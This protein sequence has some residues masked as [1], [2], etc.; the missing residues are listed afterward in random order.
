MKYIFPFLFCALFASCFN[1]GDCL[2]TATNIMHIQFKKKSNVTIDTFMNFAYHSISFSGTDTFMIVRPA[3]HEVLL[4]IDINSAINSAT[5]IFHRINPDSS[6]QATD[7]I[8]FGFN[9]QSKVISKDCGAFIFYSDL[10]ILRTNLKST[11]I[12]TYSTSLLK[13]P[14]ASSVLPSSYA[15]NYQIFY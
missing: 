13:D 3:A 15:I 12:K 14:T 8:Q 4:P 9:K 2:I 1:E 7:T 6:I 11:Q 5:L 10:K